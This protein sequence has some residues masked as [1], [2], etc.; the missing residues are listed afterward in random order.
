VLRK[1]RRRRPS[2]SFVTVRDLDAWLGSVT[3]PEAYD[4]IICAGIEQIEV[5]R[6]DHAADAIQ[7]SL[8]PGGH[9]L[10]RIMSPP[11]PASG[12]TILV[13]LLRAGLE[14][15]DSVSDSACLDCRLVRPLDWAEIARFS[16]QA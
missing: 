10:I 7:R 3:N 13:T 15:I 8:R 4:F 14:V 16:G 2:T 6:L 12:T 11:A 5:E 1:L 9:L